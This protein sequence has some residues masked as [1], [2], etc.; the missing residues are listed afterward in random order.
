VSLVNRLF[1]IILMAVCIIVLPAGGFVLYYRA[2][3]KQSIIDLQKSITEMAAQMTERETRDFIR[4]FE[5]LMTSDS[6]QVSLPLLNRALRQNPEFLY[7]SFFNIRTKK[8]FN[9]GNALFSQLFSGINPENTPLFHTVRRSGKAGIS[10]FENF[11]N[12]PVCRLVYPLGKDWYAF[13][14]IS[15]SELVGR[16]SRQHMGKSGG[17]MLASADGN[18][19]S[20]SPY[21]ENFSQED[22]KGILGGASVF[23]YSG[24]RNVYIGNYA[25]VGGQNV[26]LIAAESKNEAFAGISRITLIMLFFLLAMVTSFYFVALIF[27]AKISGP[28]KALAD[29]AELVSKGDFTA[30]VREKSDFRELSVLLY[31]FNSMIKE[32]KRYHGIQVEKVLE[33]KKKLELLVSLIRDGIILCG[34]DGELIY[35]NDTAREIL[36]GDCEA[37]PKRSELKSRLYGLTRLR[38]IKADGTYELSCRGKIKVYSVVVRK[39]ESRVQDSGVFITFHDITLD[40]NMQRMKDDFFHAVAHD[41]RVP[42]MTMQGYIH[43]LAREFPEGTRQAAYVANVKG[44]GERLFRLLENML[45]VSRLDSDGF[46]P[47]LNKT[48]AMQPV[49]EAADG[50]KLLCA[51]KGVKLTVKDTFSEPREIMMDAQL[52]R[53]VIEN[54]LSNAL[55]FTPAGGAVTVSAGAEK[56]KIFYSVE[57]TGPGIPEDKLDTVFNKYTQLDNPARE[58]GFGLGLAICRKIVN[59]HHGRIW[60]EKS[61]TGALFKIEL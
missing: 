41:V 37:E 23:E 20:L 4:R 24:D 56:D 10:D 7:I 60:A 16:L 61:E 53:R 32:L 19:L 38:G 13:A 3:A 1:S 36:R 48:D 2:E 25:R 5:R 42:L 29:S 6:E 46:T 12:V 31:S 15:A 39:L 54:L 40:R 47:A 11:Y 49:K 21:T 35:C 17:L 34:S 30:A 51:E 22:I 45:D 26:Y 50:F 28:V 44:A 58:K 27:A 43:L 52:M 8:N 33:E 57:D 55:K 14:V 18:A 59:M 9:G